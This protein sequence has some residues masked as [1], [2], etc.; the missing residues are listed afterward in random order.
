MKRFLRKD[1]KGF[2]L[3]EVMLVVLIIGII[4][5][6]ALP[7]L[8]VTKE[9]AAQKSCDSNL[10]AI[11]TQIEQYHWLEGTAAVPYPAEGP[12]AG[13]IGTFLGNAT[14][15]PADSTPSEY[16]PSDG[17]TTYT[18]DEDTGSL[19]CTVTGHTDN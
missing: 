7:K 18:Y 13:R 6:I 5:V 12:A 14:Y 11:R 2:T 10:Q 1:E 9:V 8:M 15:F 16:C 19:T 4:A 3:I 17:T